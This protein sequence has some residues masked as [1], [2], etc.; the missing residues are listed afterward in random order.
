MSGG[1]DSSVAAY[2]LKQQGYRVMGVTMKT[3]SG[4]VSTRRKTCC[5]IDDIDD[6]R[7]VAD[8]LDI[9]FMALDVEQA[10]QDSVIENFKN[11]YLRGRT[12]NPCI[13]CNT[14]MKFGHLLE[15]A[16]DLDAEFVATGHYARIFNKK[17]RFCL[18]RGRDEKKD[19]T[20]ALYNLSQDQLARTLFPLANFTK[21]EIRKMALEQG[22]RRVAAKPDSQEICFVDKDYRDFLNSVSDQPQEPGRLVNTKGEILGEHQGIAGFTIGQRKGLGISMPSKSYVT[23]INAETKEVRIGS[24][25]NL[26]RSKLTTSKLNWVSMLP[27]QQ[28]FQA[29]VKIR[30]LHSPVPAKVRVGDDGKSEV[31]FMKPEEGLTPGQSAV[32]YDGDLVLAGGIIEQCY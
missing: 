11:Q 25:E 14:E 20:Y 17:G 1:V 22:F 29:D 7:R 21:D 8:Q 18:A 30:Y 10:F 9:P 3:Y 15:V 6:A 19:Q 2:I 12:P 27:T 13:V 28:E 24:R 32:F 4:G 16:D 31:H 23:E 26:L 5:G